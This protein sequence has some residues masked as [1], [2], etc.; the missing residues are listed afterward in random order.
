VTRVV[1][2][3]KPNARSTSLRTEIRLAT[4][5]LAALSI[6]TLGCNALDGNDQ[7]PAQLRLVWH[8][9]T[10]ASEISFFAGSPTVAD[11][12][13]YLED[14][15]TLLA[16]DAKTGA[17]KWARPVRVHPTAPAR[18]VVVR[19]GRVFVSETD[20]ILAMDITDGHTLWNF[21]PDKQALVYVSADERALYTGQRDIPFVYALAV[22]DGRLL[23]KVNIGVDWT[24]PGHI[25][26]T[27]VSGDTVYVAARKWLAEN[28]Y[29]GQGVL[30]A[31]DRN[32]GQ[33]FWR[34]ET[35]GTNGGLE[36]GPVV[37][38]DLVIVSDLIG[39]AFFAYDR[40]AKRLVWRVQ[41][42][43]NGPLT[44]PVVVGDDV[45]V[46]SANTHLYA[47]NRLIGAIQWDVT[48][49]GFISGTAFCAGQVFT[50]AYQIQ[51]R[52][53]SRAGAYSGVYNYDPDVGPYTSNIATDNTNIYFAGEG[54]V[55]AVACR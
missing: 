2:S 26:G 38:G 51:R 50:Q 7:K 48:P 44:P 25:E 4:V 34:Y 5:S 43:D 12:V 18:N 21:R 47:V 33:E 39:D 1:L 8:D 14:G 19:D 28:G 27:A 49:G 6:A 41:G 30:V 42:K 40:F 10:E 54:G 46:G 11:G 36:D 15:N 16:L 55:Y 35:P 3:V 24:F 53:P 17:K 13:L 29:I 37:S 52:D 22:S 32:T 23:W 9:I 20:S 31:L 45:Y